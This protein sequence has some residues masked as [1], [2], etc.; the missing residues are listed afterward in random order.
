MINRKR[1]V[2]GKLAKVSGD[3]FETLFENQCAIQ[4]VSVV[5]I[6]NSCRRVSRFKLI[7][8]KSPFDYVLCYRNR[9]AF[10]DTKTTK[11][12]TFSY[13]MI[14]QHQV[15]ELLK[16]SPGGVSGYVIALRDEVYFVDVSILSEVKPGGS[17]DFKYAVRLGNRH[18]FDCRRMF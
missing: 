1:R 18:G 3:N 2:A 12:K 14:D 6:P 15:R 7:Q 9:S 16:L 13:S 11:Q 5:P 17:I 4:G 8:T 10:I